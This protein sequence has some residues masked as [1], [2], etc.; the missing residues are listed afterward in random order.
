MAV[1]TVLCSGGIDSWACLCWAVEKF[2]PENVRPVYYSFGQKYYEREIA[3]GLRLC[4]R[5]GLIL[6]IVRL[7]KVMTRKEFG[8][9]AHIPLRNLLFLILSAAPET[10]NGVVF[11]MLLREES[12]D[13]NPKF[14]R[15]VRALLN[16]QF[17]ATPHRPTAKPFEIYTP[18]A[19]K[20]KAEVV[21]WLTI[22]EFRRSGILDSV[23]CYNPEHPCGACISCL[24]R[25]VSLELN[26][27]YDEDKLFT[28]ETHPFWMTVAFA[29]KARKPLAPVTPWM[30]WKHRHNTI[31][32][33]RAANS[34]TKRI[35]GSSAL[36]FL[37]DLKKGIKHHV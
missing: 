1:I 12:E 9:T 25:W 37:R 31:D 35:F 18:F 3:A 2:G 22:T 33:W 13:K 17:A 5:H 7:N 36:K 11:G 16:T 28:P 32:G 8:E 23:A 21:K 30:L 20:T 10:S 14:L 26:G 19:S 4:A 34:Y 6:K 29:T 24:N 27:I 15:Q